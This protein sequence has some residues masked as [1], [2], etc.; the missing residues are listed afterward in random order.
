MVEPKIQ[1]HFNCTELCHRPKWSQTSS[2]NTITTS[3]INAACHEVSCFCSFILWINI[4]QP[5][6]DVKHIN[7][8]SQ[9]QCDRST[10][11]T[12]TDASQ[13]QHSK[14]KLIPCPLR[15]RIFA[16][17]Y[18]NPCLANRSHLP[19]EMSSKSTRYLNIFIVYQFK[20]VR[21]VCVFAAQNF[22]LMSIVSMRRQ[23]HPKN[24]SKFHA[25]A[26]WY[27]FTLIHFSRFHRQYHSVLFERANAHTFASRSKSFSFFS[28]S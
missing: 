21:A 24:D 19:P 17:K 10:K 25:N 18:Q 7:L 23:S 15:V 9:R 12:G 11:K 4:L 6:K 8:W 16:T 1:L 13:L 14:S 5:P 3:N 27:T 22:L 26:H 28:S 2:T 20:C